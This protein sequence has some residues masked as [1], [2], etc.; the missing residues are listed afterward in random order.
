M[1]LQRFGA[2]VAKQKRSSFC[3]TNRYSFS[4]PQLSD[5]VDR[6][7]RPGE[8]RD[9]RATVIIISDRMQILLDPEMDQSERMRFSQS[10]CI[11][12]CK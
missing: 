8:L 4:P 11:S 1:H 3:I 5:H 7:L 10:F 9:L 6:S 12:G 2:R